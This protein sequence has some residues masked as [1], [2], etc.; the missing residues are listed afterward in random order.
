MPS[1]L[2]A[3]DDTQLR[4]VLKKHLMDDGWVVYEA[5]DAKSALQLLQSSTKVHASVIDV[6]MPGVSGVVLVNAMKQAGL[7]DKIVT[8]V[9][10]G[11]ANAEEER[12][13]AILEPIAYLRKPFHPK[14]LVDVLNDNVPRTIKQGRTIA[15]S[16]SNTIF[17]ATPEKMR[18]E[19]AKAGQTFRGADELLKQISGVLTIPTVLEKLATTLESEDSSAR[20]LA[21]IAKYDPSVSIRLLKLVNS[22]LYSRSKDIT[23]LTQA[24]VRVGF[25]AVKNL[26]LSASLYSFIRSSER[27]G[28][29]DKEYL[30][31][32]SIGVAVLARRLA[33][34]A[35]REKDA[36]FLFTAGLL[37]DV[38]KFL[39]DEHAHDDYEKVIAFAR[40]R[41]CSLRDAE[42]TFH[43]T[44]HCEV[45]KTLLERWKLP[46]E[47]I[48]VALSHHL[49]P[50]MLEATATN[51]RQGAAIIALANRLAPLFGTGN[52]G[53][54]RIYD[55][56][57]EWLKLCR[58]DKKDLQNISN[59]FSDDLARVIDFF[60]ADRLLALHKKKTLRTGGKAVIAG[61]DGATG[62]CAASRHLQFR[63]Y[64][65]QHVDEA[66]DLTRLL[67]AWQPRIVI[68]YDRIIPDGELESVLELIALVGCVD[69]CALLGRDDLGDAP[70]PRISRFEM[71]KHSVG[72]GLLGT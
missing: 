48:E 28:G 23:D 50:S 58:I 15:K 65:V 21:E 8:V 72:A 62:I 67:Q 13:L 2:I 45:A 49:T 70:P 17:Y 30:W 47:L 33:A 20:D 4:A 40:E 43:E 24:V 10:S 27:T 60:E 41:H 18:E 44:D 68:L 61:F 56:D 54:E 31:L 42:R 1:V 26:L 11:Q 32:H 16:R 5:G 7:K 53:H 64:D 29:L 57:N 59:D 6:R 69:T 37:H 52:S 14:D 35:G 36:E 63:G 39:L 12:A 3:D 51:D 66:A 19:L 38:G 9:I 55:I 25:E 22:S 34:V 71:S 46:K